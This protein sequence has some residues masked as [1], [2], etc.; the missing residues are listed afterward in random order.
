MTEL[1]RPLPLDRIGPAAIEQVVEARPA[2]LEPLARR[3]L[4][5]AVH[6]LRCRF[7]LR[8]AGGALIE[9]DGQLEAEVVQ[10]CVASLDEFAHAVRE[11]FTVQFVPAG[12]ESE[13]DDPDSPDQIPYSGKSIDL[14]EAAAEQL[15][16][17]LDP[18]P[19][20]PGALGPTCAA[21]PASAPFAGLAAPRRKP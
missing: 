21:E 15:A 18:Y 16:L 9:A 19:R 1:P 7:R 20:K 4:I 13:D 10:V 6:R 17:A 14:G 3:L 8:R 11:A 12:T 5:P 2:E